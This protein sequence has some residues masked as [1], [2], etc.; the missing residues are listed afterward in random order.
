MTKEE[1][2]TDAVQTINDIEELIDQNRI[3]VMKRFKNNNK[4]AGQRLRARIKVIKTKLKHLRILSL[5]D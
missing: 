2:L 1:Q 5:E 3:D 4:L